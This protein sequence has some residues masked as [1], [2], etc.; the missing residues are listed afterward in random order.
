MNK[1]ILLSLL[2]TSPVFVHAMDNETSCANLILKYSKVKKSYDFCFE[3]QLKVDRYIECS[4]LGLSRFFSRISMH[5]DP[6]RFLQ[7]CYY[8]KIHKDNNNE[9][10]IKRLRMLNKPIPLQAFQNARID[11]YSA[12]GAAM[13]AKDISYDEKRDFIQVLINYDFKP[14]QKDIELAKLIL[15]DEI[16][17]QSKPMLHILYSQANWSVL[18]KEVRKT[19]IQNMIQLFKNELWLLPETAL[20]D[21]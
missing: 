18:P 11:G 17:K 9:L 12:L 20:T 21:L 19:I 3:N 4:G 5:Q 2:I 8:K 15:Y 10:D 7:Y 13:I 16:T 6:V 14:T 1:H